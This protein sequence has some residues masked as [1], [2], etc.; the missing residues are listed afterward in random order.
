MR[1]AFQGERGAY[2]EEAVRALFG[3]VEVQPCPSLRDVFDLV[4]RG[5]ADRAVVPVEN[6]QAGSINETYDLLLLHALFITGELDQRIRHCLLALPG[7]ALSGIRKV[8]SH[9][10][11]LAQCDAFL[12]QH[13]LEPVPAY[14]TAGS[15]KML[16]EQHLA[17]AAAIAG[18][19]AAQIYGLTVVAEGIE[20]NPSNY[21]KFLSLAAAPAPRTGES[22]TSIVFMTQNAPGALY[23]ALGAFAGRGINLAKLESRPR[24]QVPWEYLFYVDFEGHQDDPA[25]A[26]ALAELTGVSAFLRVLG[27]YPRS[28]TPLT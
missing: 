28:Q 27:S 19:T 24:R 8:Y 11:A 20:T 6:S 23:R 12:R 18:R 14:D 21:T 4:S 3:E 26:A 10:Q 13:A 16:A 7:Q 17:G 25:V 9:P 22:K 5:Q 15:A 2:S 1:V